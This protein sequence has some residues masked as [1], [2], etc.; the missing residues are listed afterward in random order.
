MH[1]PCGGVT[2]LFLR[3]R[4]RALLWSGR[5]QHPS[6]VRQHCDWSFRFCPTV[7]AAVCA[8]C[9][10]SSSSHLAFSRRLA[11][12]PE[13]PHMSCLPLPSPSQ[14]CLSSPFAISHRCPDHGAL[15]IV[16]FEHGVQ[17]PMFSWLQTRCCAH[18][19]M[20]GAPGSPGCQ[21]TPLVSVPV[22]S[23]LPGLV[24]STPLTHSMCASKAASPPGPL[25]SLPPLYSRSYSRG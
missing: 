8:S 7:P 1:S 25:P 10:L 19:R 9:H 3:L 20:Q 5:Q 15:L 2:G 12:N 17:W 18:T 11:Q 23:H 22:T 4:G 14:G 21:E 24:P 16:A 13:S 6:R